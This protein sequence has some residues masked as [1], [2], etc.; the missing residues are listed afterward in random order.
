MAFYELDD[1]FGYQDANAIKR[2]W[3]DAEPPANAATEEIWLDI[4]MKPPQLKR[5][6]G[7]NT[8]QTIGGITTNGTCIDITGN[9]LNDY[10]D[11]GMYKGE[12][13]TNAPT[14]AWYYF[15]VFKHTETWV[16]QI[17][18]SI[19]LTQGIQIRINNNNDWAGGWQKIWFGG[20][21]GAGSG[22]DADLL[23]GAEGSSY[24]RS[25]ADQDVDANTCWVNGKFITFGSGDKL[26]IH[27]TDVYSSISNYVGDM[28]LQ[29]KS[30]G[31]DMILRAKNTADVTLG[32][33]TLD[34]DLGGGSVRMP[35]PAGS[36][37]IGGNN[38][39]RIRH[40]GNHAYINNDYVGGL[41]L[42]NRA[43]GEN[44]YF[45]CDDAQGERV[46]M[47]HLNPDSH[48]VSVGTDQGLRL[49]NDDNTAQLQSHVNGLTIRSYADGKDINFTLDNASGV[50]KTILTLDPDGE[51]A[52][53]MGNDVWHA[54][55]D[56]A[57]SG[58]DADKLDGLQASSFIR[59]DAD[60]TFS[61]VLSQTITEGAA[62]KFDGG[63]AMITIHDGFGNFNIKSGVDETHKTVH[64]DGGAHMEMNHNGEIKLICSAA[65]LGETFTDDAYVHVKY[66][67]VYVRGALNIY[68]QIILPMAA[69]GTLTNGSMWIA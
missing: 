1:V 7:D 12:N 60:A 32:L 69:P 66:N 47:L 18:Y 21:D 68:D 61:G 10:T 29:Q 3:A 54:G 14:T 40:D 24:I 48:S 9:D 44:M 53:I 50:A 59:S 37:Y 33:I 20:S 49:Y 55:N 42:W 57:D 28:Y 26:S 19:N 31:D 4:S 6:T 13:V 34:P 43:H 15:L 46:T 36:L 22:L 64:N 67:G 25:D 52:L 16:M 45:Y 39:I 63:H 8:W 17:A 5:C 30:A 58:L 11:A 65:A 23:D 51:R 2:L 35:N 62:M 56:G 38:D 27:H 41:V